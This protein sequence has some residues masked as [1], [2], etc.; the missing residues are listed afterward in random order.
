MRISRKKVIGIALLLTL[1]GFVFFSCFIPREKHVVILATSD[2]HGNIWGYSYEDNEETNN[3]GMARLYTYIKQV[4]AENPIVFLVDAGDDIQ[5]TIMTDDIANK[6]P[7]EAHPVMAAMNFMGYDSMTI[8]NHEFNW[9]VDTMKKILSQAQ[10]PVLAENVRYKDGNYVMGQGWTLIERG[11]VKLAVIGVSNPN[12]PRWDGDKQGIDDLTY[13]G[14]DA[15]VKRALGEIGDKADIILVSAHMGQYDEYDENDSSDCG[16]VIA[17]ENPEIDLLQLGHMHITVNDRINDI[18]I[19][20]V[21]NSGR[22]IARVDLTLD[23]D[24]NIIDTETQIIEMDDFAPSQ[25]IR[26]IPLVKEMHLQTVNYLQ[27]GSAQGSESNEPLGVS[28]AKFQPENEIRGLPEGFLE[29]TAVIDLVLKVQLQN[30]DADV[31]ATALFKYTSDLP[32]GDIYYNNVFDVYKYDNTLCTVDVTG[33]ELKNYMEWAVSGYNQWKSGDINISFDSDIPYY[34]MD[35]FA[36]V[37]YEVNLSKPVGERIEN[38]YFKGSPLKDDQVLRLAVN[39]Y[40][41][42][43]ALRAEKIVENNREWESSNSIRDMI[44]EYIRKNSPISPEVDNNWHI[45]GVDLSKDDPRRAEIIGYI[46]EGVLPTP[47]V[48]SYNLAEY[49]ELVKQAKDNKAAGITFEE[50]KSH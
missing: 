6:Q 41:Y 43:S 8:G 50:P 10:F 1:T 13:E 27:N 22:E 21:R 48:K 5:G 15:A 9:G 49:D 28:T 25:E 31:T 45:T 29:D 38:V 40:R 39:N 4:R 47:N 7:D 33:K 2:M 14:G 34:R 16:G 46:N 35:Q 36:G 12:I 30:S 42:S 18:P 26:D 23:K 3:N 37:D 19:F 17:E 11:G 32:E 20:G 44:V 24:K